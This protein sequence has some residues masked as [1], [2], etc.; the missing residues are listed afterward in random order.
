MIRQTNT[1]TMYIVSQSAMFFS[2]I[3]PRRLHGVLL[4]VDDHKQNIRTKSQVLIYTLLA[5]VHSLFDTR[6]T[7]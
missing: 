7:W 6:I 5:G 2:Y 1:Q 3:R 4:S